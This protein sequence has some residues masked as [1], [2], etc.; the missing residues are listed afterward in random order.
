MRTAF[1]FAEENR[2]Y[3]QGISL[4]ESFP[5]HWKDDLTIIRNRMNVLKSKNDRIVR[6][7]VKNMRMSIG[8]TVTT[9]QDDGKLMNHNITQD[10]IKYI[11]DD[12]L[13][14]TLDVMMGHVYES[15]PPG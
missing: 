1:K 6:F 2:K 12:D 10:F 4:K 14:L 7:K 8:L 15:Y 13:N 5:A 11:D 9:R 3:A